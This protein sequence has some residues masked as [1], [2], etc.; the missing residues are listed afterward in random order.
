MGKT[1]YEIAKLSK[2]GIIGSKSDFVK[3]LFKW[4]DTVRDPGKREGD[5]TMFLPEGKF[6]LKVDGTL[7]KAGDD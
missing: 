6:I 2:A 3:D 5:V 4:R 7:E 1:R